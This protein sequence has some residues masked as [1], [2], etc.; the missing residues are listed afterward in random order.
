MIDIVFPLGGVVA[1]PKL[2]LILALLGL[3]CPQPVSAQGFLIVDAAKL[4]RYWRIEPAVL[5]MDIG[6]GR[7]QAYGCIAIGF[8][9]DRSGRVT[10]VRP[11]R[12]AFAKAV[13]PK[14][15]REFTVAIG[16]GSQM[17]GPYT[18]APE[19]PNRT[20]VFTTL[21]IPVIG[22]KLAAGLSQTQR[23]AIAA[24]LRPS[25]E[26]TDLARWVDS[27]DMRRDPEVESVPDIDFASLL[28]AD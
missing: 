15:A 26:V 10:A 20:E 3:L 14:R 8:M 1:Y 7:E 13:P 12:R 9:I 17:L 21:A 16:I 24:Q 19:N 6:N 4:D 11:L 5:A 18:P 28:G 25:C 27:H 23:E 22:R 2:L